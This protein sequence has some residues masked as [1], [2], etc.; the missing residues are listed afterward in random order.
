MKN[1][2][3]LRQ[4]VMGVG[5]VLLGGAGVLLGTQPAGREI[6]QPEVAEHAEEEETEEYTGRSWYEAVLRRDAG[7]LRQL[8]AAGELDVNLCQKV[9]YQSARTGFAEGVRMMLAVPEINVNIPG[10]F[11]GN[12]PLMAAMEHEECFRLLLADER[13]DVNHVNNDDW[14]ALDYLRNEHYET[15]GRLLLQHP[16]LD[17]E[18]YHD[19]L[20]VYVAVADVA[21][22]RRLL[23]SG[24]LSSLLQGKRY[25][26][27]LVEM[28]A[29]DV[30]REFL[31]VPGI[32]VADS[33]D[34]ME[35]SLLAIAMMNGHDECVRL[36]VEYPWTRER[37][38]VSRLGSM[39]EVAAELGRTDYMD[40]ILKKPGLWY[41][42]QKAMYT[43]A[44]QGNLAMLQRLLECPGVNVN[45]RKIDTSSCLHTVAAHGHVAVLRLLLSRPDIF[46]NR[47]N[48]AGKT[49]LQLAVEKGHAEC[50]RLLVESMAGHH[51]AAEMPGE[52][53]LPLILSPAAQA[54]R[55]S[56]GYGAPQVSCPYVHGPL[57]QAAENDNIPDLYAAL[58]KPGADVN[59][60]NND[61]KSL[62]HVVA[63][64]GNYQGVQLLL[65]QPGVD[66]NARDEAGET[67]LMSAVMGESVDVVGRLLQV[68]GVQVKTRSVHGETPLMRAA[69]VGDT[70]VVRMLLA[71]PETEAVAADV[72][73]WTALHYAARYDNAE[74][75]RQLLAEIP[76]L[77]VNAQDAEGCTPLH[78]AVEHGASGAA[79]ALLSH[80]QIHMNVRDFLGRVP[81]HFHFLFD[82]EDA[83]ER[84]RELVGLLA[85]AGADLNAR[86]RAGCTPLM[87]ALQRGDAHIVRA[88]L[89]IPGVNVNI[90]DTTGS[91]PLH[92]LVESQEL[93]LLQQ[94]LAVPGVNLQA[95]NARGITPI[96]QA[97]RDGKLG[98]LNLLHTAEYGEAP[99]EM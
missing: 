33:E 97:R 6:P 71:H 29:A 40:M 21:A 28:G 47:V 44:A 84:A 36:L 43:A 23:E 31:A 22:V 48:N 87:L 55:I 78:V 57:H 14:S 81:L 7:T 37:L 18:N 51:P 56:E 32:P 12:S 42:A 62:L 75:V 67:P 26:E 90:P 8:L 15:T 5:L 85:A 16:E 83:E 99:P 79:A 52:S 98:G 95:R 10:D 77:D 72:D 89:G 46:V 93:E 11:T 1:V 45:N 38:P 63:G 59:A 17:V 80:P 39:L 50:A 27:R 91:S 35:N 68:S 88:L 20:G 96:E 49:A 19:K 58:S 65:Q 94:L 86:D 3:G 25:V 53:W 82:F 74:V 34:D 2:S 41:Y 70:A 30:L 4:G 92:Y 24:E 69:S 73:G 13:V 60:R 66:V 64:K 9:L 61:A 76:G 54:A